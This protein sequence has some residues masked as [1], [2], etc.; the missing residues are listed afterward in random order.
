MLCDPRAGRG[1]PAEPDAPPAEAARDDVPEVVISD[2]SDNGPRRGAP[3]TLRPVASEV[4]GI[5][6][7]VCLM[8]IL[9]GSDIG[10]FIIF[11]KF[12]L[13]LLFFRF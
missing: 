13:F 12:Y 5:H 6:C 9:L 8:E 4:A 10:E 2:D 11:Y 7:S 1:R 3:H